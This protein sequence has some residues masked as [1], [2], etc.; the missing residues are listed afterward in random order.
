VLLKTCC[1]IDLLM[2]VLTVLF[3]SV[4]LVFAVPQNDQLFCNILTPPP[5]SQFEF[6]LMS[7]VRCSVLST[8]VLCG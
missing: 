3:V 5:K 2:T 6:G 7:T 8:V 4:C 1:P